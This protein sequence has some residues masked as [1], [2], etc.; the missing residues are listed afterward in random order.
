M[1]PLA[2]ARAKARARTKQP[3]FH[4]SATDA[5]AKGTL[6]GFVPRSRA[7]LASQE[8]Q[9]ARIA[10]ARCT[11]IA[12][13]HPKTE[14]SGSTQARARTW[15]MKQAKGKDMTGYS[16]GY[17]NKGKGKGKFNSFDDGFAPPEFEWQPQLSPE[18][19][20]AAA[21]AWPPAAA[22]AAPPVQP[23]LPWMAAATGAP[24]SDP[25]S[26]WGSPGPQ[27]PGA[28][29]FHSLAPAPRQIS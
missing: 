5:T 13:V 7:C 23:Q 19:S 16:K 24:P 15:A 29:G 1:M 18:W 26:Q 14:A 4:W 28:S 6:I 21:S 3:G 2:N 12:S 27:W 20:P 10:T 11:A 8:L 17:G 25:W 22:S 9:Y